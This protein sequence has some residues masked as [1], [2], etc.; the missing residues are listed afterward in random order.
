LN[1][2]DDLKYQAL[3]IVNNKR[4]PY[5]KFYVVLVES[6]EVVIPEELLKKTK[7]NANRTT[8]SAD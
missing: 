6:N 3:L 1:M 5:E 2:L 4:Y 7:Q 8:I